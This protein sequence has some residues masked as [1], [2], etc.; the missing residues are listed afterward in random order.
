MLSTKALLTA[1]ALIAQSLLLSAQTQGNSIY[2]IG[3]FNTIISEPYFDHTTTNV[4]SSE[5][6]LI[7]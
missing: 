3:S 1:W 2:S 4:A 7:S 5:L 6:I